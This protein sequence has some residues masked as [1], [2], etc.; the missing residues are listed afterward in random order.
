M[1]NL[2]P[3]DLSRSDGAEKDLVCVFAGINWGKREEGMVEW[4]DLVCVGLCGW[5][6]L[7]VC[8]I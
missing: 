7:R 5:V 6:C 4:L 8:A 1:K 2:A 3:G